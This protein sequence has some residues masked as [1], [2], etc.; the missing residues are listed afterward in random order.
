MT[1]LSTE[2]P[3]LEL[4]QVDSGYGR[5][6]VLRGIT[7]TVPHGKIT[8]L[9]GPNGAGKTT[10]LGSVSG[11]VRTFSGRILFKGEDISHL[12]TSKRIAQGLCHIPERRGVFRSLSVRDNLS[13][14]ARR[15]EERDSL[16][17]AVAAFPILGM[18]LS[19]IAGTLSGGQQQ[20]LAMARAYAQNP[21]LVMVDE[22]S[23]GLAPTIVDQVFDFLVDL[24]SRGAAVLAVDQYATRVL[25]LADHAY[26]L[27]HGEL[28][29]SGQPAQLAST[30]IF[31]RYLGGKVAG[32]LVP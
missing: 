11:L 8:A 22:A 27:F 7:L 1:V 2:L 6:R 28:V 24:P 29:F 32:G 9:V 25:G 14:H 16:E 13:M 31:E 12:A 10:L 30:D 21:D 17:R 18:R 20:M 19:Q 5:V 15:R 3:I 26:V 23:L 4:K